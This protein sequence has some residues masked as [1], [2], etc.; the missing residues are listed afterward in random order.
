MKRVFSAEEI[1]ERVAA[2]EHGDLFVYLVTEGYLGEDYD[3]YTS[4]F[5]KGATTR[6]DR[7][8]VQRFNKSDEIPFGEKIDTPS[9]ILLIL[10]DGLFGKPQG[11]N[12]TI[13][14]HVLG[15]AA[16]L[17]RP[18]LVEGVKA[19]P[20]EAF[21]FLEAYYVE[22]EYPE[23]L[24]WTLIEAWDDFLDTTAGCSNPLP[25]MKEILKRA[26]DSTIATRRHPSTF[27]H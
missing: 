15:E 11:F 5:H 7:E 6:A 25:H 13:V 10:D 4:Y 16:A 26:K 1:T 2:F 8:F 18:R 23:K 12:I 14:D 17:H 22:G 3:Y 20:N 9:E 24:L 27:T 19:F 21:R